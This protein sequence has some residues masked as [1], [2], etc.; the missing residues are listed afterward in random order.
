MA[1]LA[2]DKQD[3]PVTVTLKAET[4]MQM[5]VAM[6]TMPQINADEVMKLKEAITVA[7]GI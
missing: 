4:A 3:I 5:M 7:L 2:D 6:V 1:I